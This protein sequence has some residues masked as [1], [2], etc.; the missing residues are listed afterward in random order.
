MRPA[1]VVGSVMFSSAVSVGTRL[2]AWKMKPIL[3]RRSC[4]SCLSSSV[5]EVDVA[6]EH[7]AGRQRV[8]PGDAVHQRA[9][10]GAARAHDRGELA[11]AELDRD[12][13]ERCHG[14]VALSVALGGPHAARAAAACV[15]W[16]AA[17]RMVW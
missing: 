3:S 7:L 17:W 11:R 14:G 9:L 13:V 8:E 5:G 2:N 15:C 4:V 12:G 1:S 16:A 10:A 6:D